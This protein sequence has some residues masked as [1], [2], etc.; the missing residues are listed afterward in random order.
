M[1]TVELKLVQLLHTPRIAGTSENLV[2][3]GASAHQ[4]PFRPVLPN[5]SLKH[6]EQK[7]ILSTLQK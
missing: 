3:T 7:G 5:N 4:S 6:I 2:K 1:D